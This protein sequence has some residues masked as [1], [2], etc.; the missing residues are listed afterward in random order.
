MTQHDLIQAAHSWLTVDP[1]AIE[2]F[3][4]WTTFDEDDRWGLI[5]CPV[6][7]LRSDP[8]LDAHFLPEDVERFTS[9]VPQANIRLVEGAGHSILLQPDGPDRYLAEL[10]EFLT[11]LP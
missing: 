10:D 5:E 9:S 6:T 3:F 7:I 1:T 2:A 8:T 4:R 11:T